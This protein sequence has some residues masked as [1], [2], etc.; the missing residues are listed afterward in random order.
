MTIRRYTGLL[1]ATAVVAALTGGPARAQVVDPAE[2]DPQAASRERFDGTADAAAADIVVT[3]RG[4][5]A[6]GVTNTTPGGRLMS[7]QT[8]TKLR[9]TVNPTMK[10]LA[11]PHLTALSPGAI[12]Q[13][14]P[15]IVNRYRVPT[16][17][18]VADLGYASRPDRSA[19]IG[20]A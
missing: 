9:N 2:G 10:P 14:I 12:D 15:H 11:N 1:L 19:R 6:N 8:G 16:F 3:G 20:R 4:S 17:P 18:W 7:V 13:D 5:S